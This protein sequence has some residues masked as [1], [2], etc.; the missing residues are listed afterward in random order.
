MYDS[1]SLVSLSYK[2]QME[3]KIK[4]GEKFLRII[5]QENESIVLDLSALD[6]LSDPTWL[7]IA[8]EG[9]KT[10]KGLL[11]VDLTDKQWNEILAIKKPKILPRI[12]VEDVRCC[13]IHAP[14]AYA[15]CLGLKKS[16]NR[17]KASPFRGWLLIQS[18]KSHE[19]DGAIGYY[20]LNPDYMEYGAIIGAAFMYDC[21][22]ANKSWSYLLKDPVLFEEPLTISGKQAPIWSALTDKE[23]RVFQRAI[24]QIV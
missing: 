10:A 20:E 21:K 19:S 11:L 22:G 15:V 14:Y 8:K 13:T 4:I 23:K 16:E 2:E 5:S 7:E 3:Y 1:I 6:A 12:N 9:S 18:G 24:A 17:R